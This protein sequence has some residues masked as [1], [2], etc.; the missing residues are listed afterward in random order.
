[1]K[2]EQMRACCVTLLVILIVCMMLRCMLK[3]KPAGSNTCGHRGVKSH[4]EQPVAQP[5]VQPVAH[6]E[7]VVYGYMSCPYTAKQVQYM[8]SNNIKYTFVDTKTEEG[9]MEL[10]KITGGGTGV[11][12]IV[13]PVSNK[14]K[15]GY[16][17]L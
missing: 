4:H 17:E 9:S 1:M 2:S 14:F 6:P 11:P 7:Y 16:T 5:V 3:R 8:E 13:N 15:V 12:V 10:S